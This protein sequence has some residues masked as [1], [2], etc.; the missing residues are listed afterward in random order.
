MPCSN[1]PMRAFSQGIQVSL[2][3]KEQGIHAHEFR[4]E[5]FQKHKGWILQTLPQIFTPRSVQRYRPRL[6]Q[7]YQTVL[8]LKPPHVYRKQT[9]P[10]Q[11]VRPMIDDDDDSDDVD[12]PAPLARVQ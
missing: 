11:G 4:A 12:E 3:H 7:M 9:L 1:A 10:A 5:F 2:K 6:R 8:N